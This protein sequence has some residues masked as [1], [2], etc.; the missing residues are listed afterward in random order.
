MSHS[1]IQT[2]DLAQTINASEYHRLPRELLY[3]IIVDIVADSMDSVWRADLTPEAETNPEYSWA[4]N[5]IVTLCGVS[6][7]FQAII[8]DLVRR[9]FEISPPSSDRDSM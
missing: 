4:R 6:F 9:A 3:D 1:L 7:T 8:E 5:A 2:A